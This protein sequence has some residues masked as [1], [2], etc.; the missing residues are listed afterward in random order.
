M[1]PDV[2]NDIDDIHRTANTDGSF[3]IS[4]Q[5]AAEA[6]RFVVKHLKKGVVPL[7]IEVAD[8]LEKNDR[9]TREV[10]AL[11]ESFASKVTAHLPHTTGSSVETSCKFESLPLEGCLC[12]ACSNSAPPFLSLAPSVMGGQALVAYPRSSIS[13]GRISYMGHLNC[14][15]P[16]KL[17]AGVQLDERVGWTDGCLQGERY[18]TCKPR[19]GIFVPFSSIIPVQGCQRTRASVVQG[20]S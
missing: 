12:R 16:N 7:C 10:R 13:V 5:H 11:K 19:Y 14:G 6:V 1:D 17:W 4:R 2:R 3:D 15:A 20:F 8:V 18:F 9:L